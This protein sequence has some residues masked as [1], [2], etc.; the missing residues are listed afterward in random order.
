MI[1]NAY[2][3]WMAQVLFG[4]SERLGM[5]RTVAKQKPIVREV[6][7]LVQGGVAARTP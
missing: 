4:N 6:F 7:P 1:G 5:N 3:V 2:V